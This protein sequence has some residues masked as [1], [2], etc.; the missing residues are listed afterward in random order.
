M[1]GSR[2]GYVRFADFVP[3]QEA[4]T[5]VVETQGGLSTLQSDDGV[6]LAES[7][8]TAAVWVRRGALTVLALVVA[9]GLSTYLGVHTGT[10][11]ADR[12]Q[13]GLSLKYPQVARPGLDVRWQATVTHPGGFDQEV[14]LAVSGDYF[15]IF[16]TQG[17]HP[18][19]SDETRDGR[20][21][22]LTFSA[23]P[24][25]TFVVDFDTYVQPASQSGR[26][27]TL[28]VVDNRTLTPLTSVDFRTRVMP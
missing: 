2:D 21:L 24:G 16:E 15:D 3:D 14:T 19:P 10:A 25:E 5:E 4:G 20:M 18:Q 22:Y 1:G 8:H 23:P 6:P 7:G 17:F 28:A 26:S 12:G 27:G 11:S 13:W 9:L